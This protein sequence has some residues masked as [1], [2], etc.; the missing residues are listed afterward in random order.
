MKTLVSSD[1]QK[2]NSLKHK[3][4]TFKTNLGDAVLIKEEEKN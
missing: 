2:K 4:K 1:P 3:D